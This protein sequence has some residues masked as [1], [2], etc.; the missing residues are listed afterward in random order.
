MRRERSSSTRPRRSFNI[1]NGFKAILK[2]Q[3]L[4]IF[5]IYNNEPSLNRYNVLKRSGEISIF[6]CLNNL[7]YLEMYSIKYLSTINFIDSRIL[8]TSWKQWVHIN[9]PTSKVWIKQQL[10]HTKK[11]E[12]TSGVWSNTFYSYLTG[13]NWT[14]GLDF[15]R[16][17]G[18]CR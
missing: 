2:T 18:D 11:I 7:F 3:V 15:Y 14:Q 5:W 13:S 10:T 1:K 16:R 12:S 4:L 8:W 6:Y 9:A 17:I